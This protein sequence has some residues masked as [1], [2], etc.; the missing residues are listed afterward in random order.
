MATTVP[1]PVSDVSPAAWVSEAIRGF[2]PCVDHQVPAGRYDLF[3]RVLH[4]PDQGLQNPAEAGSWAAVAAR[5][6]TTVHAQAEFASIAR[7]E[8]GLG[9]V[10]GEP[11]DGSLDRITLPALRD[12]LRR[13][14][15]TADRCWFALWAG[16]GGEPAGW[17]DMPTFETPGRD[18]WLFSGPLSSVLDLSL[19]LA[20]AGSE[21][22]AARGVLELVSTG[23]ASDIDQVAWDQDMRR[24]DIVQSP[25]LW[26]PDDRS[27]FVSSEI[28]LDS[29]IVA[30]TPAL[31]AEILTHPDLE[32]LAVSATTSLMTG[33]DQ[34]NPR[35]RRDAPGRRAHGGRVA[36]FGRVPRLLGDENPKDHGS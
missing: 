21:E 6:G 2:G 20:H 15:A 36:R 30:G 34:I 22:A 11:Y 12:V 33:S 31:I 14:T 29:T 1:M 17:R 26:W 7:A 4:R 25:N 23:E 35:S 8:R 16:Y 18:Y 19:D 32:A 9:V 10:E 13:H 24:S 28:D 5:Y 27:W 3:A